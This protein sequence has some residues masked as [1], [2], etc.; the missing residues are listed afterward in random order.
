MA[1]KRVR[2]RISKVK[3]AVVAK[4]PPAN[5][6]PAHHEDEES[7]PNDEDGDI[8]LLSEQL[9]APY[10]DNDQLE[11][12]ASFQ[13]TPTAAPREAETDVE[14][15]EKEEREHIG[16]P[17][18]EVD[19]VAEEKRAQKLKLLVEIVAL[20]GALENKTAELEKV[21]DPIL[22]QRHDNALDIF[23]NMLRTKQ[24]ELARLD[25]EG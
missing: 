25:L 19:D 6:A 7:D 8:E 3:E 10:D 13:R 11:E 21:N 1:R 22:R 17:E 15:S 12:V 18:P 20:R 23:R 16:S 9:D 4:T 2:K 24:A 5:G 14:T